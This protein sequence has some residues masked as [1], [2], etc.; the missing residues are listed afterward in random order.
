MSD[1]VS[2]LLMH[3]KLDE[4]TGTTASDSSG[5]G[6]DGTT[7]NMDDSNWVGGIIVTLQVQEM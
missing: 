6:Y 5:N 1:I 2:D 7:Q 3:W 4:T